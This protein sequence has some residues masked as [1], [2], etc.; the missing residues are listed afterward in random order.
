MGFN[1]SNGG[2]AADTGGMAATAGRDSSGLI[3]RI[4]GSRTI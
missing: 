1:C 4:A 2:S 3:V